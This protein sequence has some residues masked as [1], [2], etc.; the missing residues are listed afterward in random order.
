MRN[1]RRL[2]LVFLY[3]SVNLTSPVSRFCSDNKIPE[4][5]CP[6]KVTVTG[7]PLCPLREE[8]CSRS[9]IVLG[10]ARKRPSARRSPCPGRR[11]S[12][13][14]SSMDI[15]FMLNPLT[16]SRGHLLRLPASREARPFLRPH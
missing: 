6:S 3:F 2:R 16:F 12:P 9:T 1:T 4:D 10:T 5:D 14:D 11:V 8:A 7:C 13:V 15:L